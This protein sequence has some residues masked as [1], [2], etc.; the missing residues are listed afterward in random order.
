FSSMEHLKTYTIFAVV[1]D[2]EAPRDLVMQLNLFAGQLYLRSYGEYKRLCRYLGL[3]YT[4]NEDGEM[5]VPPDGFDGKRKY[6]EC[7]FESSPVAF[8]AKVYEIRSDYVGGAEKTHMGEILAGE[9]LTE[10]DF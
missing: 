4:E 7:E 10:R 8:L 3:A 2:W 5:A 9:I 6:P 1:A